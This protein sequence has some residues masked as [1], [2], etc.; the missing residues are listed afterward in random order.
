MTPTSKPE[1]IAKLIKEKKPTFIVGVP[2][3]YESLSCSRDFRSSDLSRLKAA[4]SG[5]DTL[6]RKTKE[7]FEE[8]V[9]RGGGN[10]KLLEGYGLT[11]AV[12]AIMAT[13]LT[14]YREGSIGIP[15]PDIIAKIVRE[16]TTEVAPVGDDGELCIH[17]PPVMI[18][19]LGEPEDTANA[20]IKHADGRVWLHTGD[21]ASMDEDGFFY[22]KLRL[23]RII[24]TAGLNVYPGQV[25]EVLSH[26][27]AV[28]VACVIGV[29][30]R[31]QG[32]RAKAFVVL[33]DPSGASKEMERELIDHCTKSLISWSCPKEVE[34]RKELPLTPTGKLAFK[35][36]EKEESE[37]LRF[38][39]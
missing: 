34:F 27:P 2:T 15:Y 16:G 17:G 23:K 28:K 3:L 19:Y 33:E 38:E 11:E 14:E 18:G 1:T 13:P 10:I 29:P 37:R 35:E 12:T 8:T 4:F 36:L 21:V 30:D 31:Y 6:P 26:H 9:R 22:Y 20:L 24:K 25:E 5:A 32:E 7:D 39:K